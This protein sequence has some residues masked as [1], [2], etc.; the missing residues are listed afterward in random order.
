MNYLIITNWTLY[1]WIT[2]PQS[3]EPEYLND[4][5]NARYEHRIKTPHFGIGRFHWSD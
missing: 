2:D 1:I 4:T 5:N 3:T